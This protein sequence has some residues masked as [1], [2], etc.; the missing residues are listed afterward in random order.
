MDV[1][2]K[3]GNEIMSVCLK[4]PNHVS[5]NHLWGILAETPLGLTKPSKEYFTSE[6]TQW[7]SFTSE[8]IP[9]EG[10]SFET[11]IGLGFI[12]KTVF[13]KGFTYEITPLVSYPK[14][15]LEGFT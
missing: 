1:R 9:K 4:I 6:T 11:T 3:S 15:S 14:P 10:F 13:Q 2:T 8:T 12:F 5:K 7:V